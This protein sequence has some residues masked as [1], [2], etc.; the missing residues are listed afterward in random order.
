MTAFGR[1]LNG[2]I[3]V[4]LSLMHLKIGQSN[5]A[6]SWKLAVYK[7]VVGDIDRTKAPMANV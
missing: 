7:A 4:F 2:V 1:G 3:S 5:K 6:K